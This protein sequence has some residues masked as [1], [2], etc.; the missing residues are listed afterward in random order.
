MY[1]LK[2][3][4]FEKTELIHKKNL[5]KLTQNEFKWKVLKEI[6]RLNNLIKE[7]ELVIKNIKENREIISE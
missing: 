5:L 3:L 7:I 1:D 2:Q 6:W 4:L